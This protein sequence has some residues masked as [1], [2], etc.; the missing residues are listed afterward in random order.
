MNYNHS[1]FYPD[2]SSRTAYY[3]HTPRENISN[4]NEYKRIGSQYR[5]REL[6]NCYDYSAIYPYESPT[7]NLEFNKRRSLSS[8]LLTQASFNNHQD[9][10]LV[11]T[12]ITE[13]I[14]QSRLPVSSSNNHQNKS[15]PQIRQTK[16]LNI[17]NWIL[18]SNNFASQDKSGS[19]SQNVNKGAFKESRKKSVNIIIF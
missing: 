9:E 18:T 16:F 3:S 12:K 1:T 15:N 4:L 13:N 8:R 11:K 7:T 10:N 2:V 17:V 14:N 5:R 19:L 6:E